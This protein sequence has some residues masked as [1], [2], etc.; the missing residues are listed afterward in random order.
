[1]HAPASTLRRTLP[2]LVAALVL[3]AGCGGSDDDDGPDR[4]SDAPT[5]T[6]ADGP[7]DGDGGGA[8]DDVDAGADGL[9]DGVLRLAVVGVASLDPGDA[10]PASVSQ[11][12]VADLVADTLVVVGD[13]GTVQPGLAE[14]TADAERRTW[15]FRL[16]EDATF[17]DG[18]ALT[19]EDVRT[20]LDRVRARG[21]G[22]L[23]A[24]A[25]EDVVEV[26]AV[27]A[28][29][30]EVVLAAPS[31]TLPERLT[32]PVYGIV[33]ADA[34][35]SP[36]AAAPGG[37][38]AP[39][40]PNAS[41]DHVV[42]VTGP[43]SVALERRRGEGPARV[44]LL[45]VDDVAAAA[46]ALASGRVDWAPVPADGLGASLGEGLVADLQPFHGTVLLGVSTTVSPLEDGRL[47]RA[48]GL[49]VDRGPLV[50]AVFGPAALPLGGLVPAGVPGGGRCPDPCGPGQAEARTLVGQVEA[51]GRSTSLRLLTD[52]S[53]VQAAVAGVLV[54]QL[55]AA[56]IEVT[57][58][59]TPV[60]T[61]ESLVAAGQQQLVLYGTLGVSRTPAA[62]LVSWA[63]DSPDNV[64]RYGDELVDAAIAAA[65][66][67]P[68]AAT[69][70]ARW[71]EIEDALIGAGAVV[72]LAQLRTV[73]A[74]AVGVEGFVVRADGSV[75][76]S[77]VRISR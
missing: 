65:R 36:G 24:L 58:M 70:L 20:S 21:S 64:T 9:D 56:G 5:T 68:L 72:P 10:S 45:L 4:S 57:A 19:A 44:E 30:V 73:A 69:R 22:S 25:L 35:G 75:D 71:A 37:R 1:M 60:S 42:S 14:V 31:A 54:D 16:R 23:A 13:D 32:S 67:E 59:P 63:S 7:A 28:D 50:D 61:Y 15:R 74:T 39:T 48:V 47:R 11:V 3:L 26:R 29:T 43:A 49:A 12:L 38:G 62:H 18:T 66:T 53:E 77:G 76:L 52:D 46:D 27:A 55:G 17:A 40:A 41:G 8:G 51:D 34:P 2:A 33:D 6:D